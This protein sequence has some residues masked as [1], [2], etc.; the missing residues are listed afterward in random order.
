MAQC[1]SSFEIMLSY[2]FRIASF[3]LLVSLSGLQSEAQDAPP[4]KEWGQEFNTAGAELKVKE[5]NREKV[6]RVTVVTYQFLAA[7]LPKDKTY[8]FW[9]WELGRDPQ[10]GLD[11]TIDSDGTLLTKARPEQHVSADPITLKFFG[12]PAEPK[13]FALLSL[14]GQLKAFGK[15]IPFPI[16]ST[17]GACRLSIEM[18][19][20]LYTLVNLRVDGL[21]PNES[22]QVT[23][24]SRQEHGRLKPK[25]DEL[26]RWSSV[27]GPYVKGQEKGFTQVEI[28]ATNC[29]PKVEFPWGVHYYQ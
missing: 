15:T 28:S 10:F 23:L 3:L 9:V 22:F 8:R 6:E 16:E 11:A 2:G 20:P 21:K 29:K 19:A 25:A 14:D 27:I 5:V 18:A 26:G 1:K 24:Q 7:G 12:V 4:Y 13:R 17:D